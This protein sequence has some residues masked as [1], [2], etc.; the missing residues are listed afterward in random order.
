MNESESNCFNLAYIVQ[1]L[2]CLGLAAS[3]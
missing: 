3:V 2:V 1:L